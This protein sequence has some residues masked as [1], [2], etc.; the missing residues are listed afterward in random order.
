M[1]R[2]SSGAIL[3]LGHSL[4]LGVIA[5]GIETEAQRLLLDTLGCREGQGFLFG[6]PMPAE[7]FSAY[8]AKA[9]PRAA[10]LTG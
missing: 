4:G 2:R 10:K 8:L 9:L 6:A 5:E 3:A 1:T 7:D